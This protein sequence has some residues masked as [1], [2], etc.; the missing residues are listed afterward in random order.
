MNKRISERG[1]LSTGYWV[2]T[3]DLPLEVTRLLLEEATAPSAPSQQGS[4]SPW[5]VLLRK[6]GW[7][8]CQAAGAWGSPSLSC[9]FGLAGAVTFP[10]WRCPSCRLAGCPGH[11]GARSA[12]PGSPFTRRGAPSSSIRPHR[13]FPPQLSGYIPFTKNNPDCKMCE[14]IISKKARWKNVVRVS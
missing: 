14:R 11:Q 13:D 7:G 5:V 12:R 3:S 9:F 10:T 2:Q 4:D 8:S 1:L 6:H